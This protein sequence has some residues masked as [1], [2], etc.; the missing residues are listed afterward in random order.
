MQIRRYRTED[1]GAV[2]ALHYAGLAQMGGI[3]DPYHDSD[4]DDIEGV[5]INTYGAFLVGTEDSEIV[6]MGA[7]RQKSATCGEIKRIRVRRDCQRRGYAQ[8]ILQK[9]I[10]LAAEIGYTELCLDATVDNIPAQRLF[11]KC[12]F[13]KTHE[14]KVGIYDLVFYGKKLHEGGE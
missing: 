6:A 9:L 12:G 13:T 14:G 5:Y 10:E 4:L 11:E 3:K 1:N 8:T 7:I 2:K